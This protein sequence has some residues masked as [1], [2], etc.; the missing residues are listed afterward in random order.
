MYRRD[1][2]MVGLLKTQFSANTV[3]SNPIIVIVI[4]AVNYGMMTN[5]T[6]KLSLIKSMTVDSLTL[7]YHNP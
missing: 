4:G 6:F 1:N 2:K 5:Q 7:L 3:E